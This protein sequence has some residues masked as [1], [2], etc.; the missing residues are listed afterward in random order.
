MPA[1]KSN[2][3][4]GRL[5][6]HA[7]HYYLEQHGYEVIEHNWRCIEGEIDIV[8]RSGADWVFV[9]VK[10]RR[11]EQ[12]GLPEDAI[13]AAKRKKLL[14]CGLMY[15]AEHLADEANWRIDVVAIQL[16]R[17]DLVEDIRLYKNAVR[18]NGTL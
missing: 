18:A 15:M 12:F 9:E 3:E 14:R 16:S 11:G 4:T 8:A 7:A 13:T 2:T 6:E 10:A 5:G 1:R 17:N